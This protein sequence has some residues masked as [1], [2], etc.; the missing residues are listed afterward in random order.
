MW[1]IPRGLVIILSKQKKLQTMPFT[2]PWMQ[3][4]PWKTNPNLDDQIEK[5]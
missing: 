3:K 2:N 1:Y 4:I 5:Q